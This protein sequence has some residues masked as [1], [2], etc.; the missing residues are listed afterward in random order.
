MN[1]FRLGVRRIRI[2][3][4]REPSEKISQIIGNRFRLECHVEFFHWMNIPFFPTKKPWLLANKDEYVLPTIQ[5]E[6][7]LNKLFPRK[8]KAPWTY[9]GPIIVLVVV[10]ILLAPKIQSTDTSNSVQPV[11]TNSPEDQFKRV[12]I[13][14]LLTIIDL[15]PGQILEYLKAID[16]GW[17]SDRSNNSWEFP[18][19]SGSHTDRVTLVQPDQLKYESI[20][21][22]VPQIVDRKMIAAGFTKTGKQ[23]FRSKNYR[24]TYSME[25]NSGVYGRIVIK[26]LG[27]VE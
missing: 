25:K 17:V 20:F 4:Y 9:S 16:D 6:A 10:A 27:E 22:L 2:K 11:V 3:H 18:L 24:A 5:Q 15:E 23:S 1:P 8:P 7:E 12:E 21:L 13:S 14:D 26:R 19:P